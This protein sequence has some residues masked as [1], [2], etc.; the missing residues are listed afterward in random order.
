V[1][2]EPVLEVPKHWQTHEEAVVYIRHLEHAIHNLWLRVQLAQ[3]RNPTQENTT[4]PDPLSEIAS[5]GADFGTILN[6]LTAS[7]SANT[8][9]QALITQLE[10]TTD[11]V[12]PDVQAALDNL[13]TPTVVAAAAAAPSAASTPAPSASATGT[14][15]P[16]STSASGTGAASTPSST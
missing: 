14:P 12:S 3:K 6:A 15:S 16:A 5:V 13:Q 10:S 9:A 11:T 4:M 2:P 7:Q 8:A 1:E